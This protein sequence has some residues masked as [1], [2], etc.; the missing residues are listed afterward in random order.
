MI[1]YLEA[2][3]VEKVATSVVDTLGLTHID[4]S[5]IRF[6]R[7]KGSKSRSIIARIHGLSR[8]WRHTVET[9]VTYVIEVLS[10]HYDRLPEEERE[11]TLIHELLHVPK[12]FGG[13][14]LAHRGH[15]TRR[16]VEM[17]YGVYRRAKQGIP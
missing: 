6:V 3:D 4:L 8:L 16:Q 1:E 10:E 7:S 15:V 17:L 11:K 2:H 13:G 12:A 9:R 5:R 14:L